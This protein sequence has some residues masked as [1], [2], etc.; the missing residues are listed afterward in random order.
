MTGTQVNMALKPEPFSPHHASSTLN[1]AP[2]NMEDKRL[3]GLQQVS[4]IC[5]WSCA[6]F[7]NRG[8]R[9]QGVCPREFSCGG[10][11]QDN[12][13]P[14]PVVCGLP[15]EVLKEARKGGDQQSRAFHQQGRS[16]VLGMGVWGNW[17]A[18]YSSMGSRQKGTGRE[19]RCLGLSPSSILTP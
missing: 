6:D 1:L 4:M 8:V 12:R 5:T 13:K 10:K 9:R 3:N 18:V 14:K 19:S 2:C 15:P 17:E 7:W 16:C 11:T